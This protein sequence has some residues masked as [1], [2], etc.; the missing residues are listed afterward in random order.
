MET[1]GG[2]TGPVLIVAGCIAANHFKQ[3]VDRAITQATRATEKNPAVPA[4]QLVS[5]Q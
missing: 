5:T 2:T 3:E 1:L 4:A